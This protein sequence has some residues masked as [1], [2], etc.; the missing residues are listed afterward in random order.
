MSG[1]RL[2]GVGEGLGHAGTRQLA[3]EGLTGQ[4]SGQQALRPI[5]A[6]RSMPVSKPI[7]SSMKTRSSVATLPLAPGA[8]GQPPSPPSE[9]S[10]ERMPVSSAATTLARPRPRVSWKCADVR[11][12]PATSLHPAEKAADL[13]RV[14]V[15]DGIGQPHGVGAGFRQAPASLTTASSGTSPWMVQPKAVAMPAST[16]TG[17]PAS[18]RIRQMRAISATISSGV[19]RTLARLCASLAESGTIRISAPA[20]MAATAPLRFGTRAVTVTPGSRFAAATTSAASAICGR[21]FAG[22]KDATSKRRTPLP[23][24]C[25]SHAILSLVG[26]T[27]SRICNPSRR[28]TSTTSIFSRCMG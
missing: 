7:A 2:D 5:S 15:A 9:A 24:S 19:R 20:S 4:Q 18:S 14:G 13:R 23:C 16:R 22:T 6:S 1:S 26:T 8:C 11:R 10:K 28:P 12:S 17:R 25:V 3:V 27:R 21:S